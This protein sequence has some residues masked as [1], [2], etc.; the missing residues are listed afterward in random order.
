MAYAFEKIL[1]QVDPNKINLFAQQAGGSQPEIAGTQA[2]ETKTET[3]GAVG[4]GGG[5]GAQVQS[6]SVPSEGAAGR[7][8][9]TQRAFEASQ[10]SGPVD[11]GKSFEQ[12]SA[13][14]A[15][16]QKGLQEE[17]NK[18]REE[19]MARQQYDVGQ[20]VIEKAIKGDKEAEGKVATTLGQTTPVRAGAWTPKTDYTIE[21]VERYGSTP[22]VRKMLF[23]QAGP[24]YTAGSAALD[25][26]R[27]MADPT[28]QRSLGALRTGQKEL[29]DIA[30]GY[31]DPEKGLQ[32]SIE[33]AGKEKLETSQKAIKEKL[34][35][36]LKNLETTNA[37]EFEQFV[38][39]VKALSTSG[40]EKQKEVIAKSQPEIAKR[41]QEVIQIR[42]DLAKYLTPDFINAFSINPS[43]Y[44]K[45]TAL[46]KVSAE[47][48]YNPEEAATFNRIMGLLGQ[49]GPAKMAGTMPGSSGYLDVDAYTAALQ[50]AAEEKNRAA[51]IAARQAIDQARARA[52]AKSAQARSQIADP[53]FLATLAANARASLGRGDIAGDIIDPYQFYRSGEVSGSAMDYLDP[54]DVAAVNAAYEELMTPMNVQAG[55]LFNA[56]AY[57]FDEQAYKAA[58]LA[59]LNELSAAP[60]VSAPIPPGMPGSTA[61]TF[62]DD[63]EGGGGGGSMMPGG[64]PGKVISGGK[65]ALKKLK[66]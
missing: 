41:I 24:G 8:V 44:V 42:P 55:R 15:A 64:I 60:M 1:S 26:A 35:G 7:S 62:P 12:T 50:G 31:A 30:K 14:I 33:T 4:T 28:Y 58:V 20:D 39:E 59:R 6:A 23:Q 17:A 34:G 66:F 9:G 45:A 46:D 27:L 11:L 63:Y 56:P 54:A 36:A 18:Y 53:N 48:F 52:E 21:E 37:A 19:E 57:T 10:K 65:K 61:I 16:A 3:G 2:P 29:E 38:D 25:A 51:D 47:N 5:A 22:G 43:A 40:S 49:G 32:K 13:K